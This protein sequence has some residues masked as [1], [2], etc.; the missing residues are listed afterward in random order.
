MMEK[1]VNWT[2][3]LGGCFDLER[4]DENGYTPATLC[5]NFLCMCVMSLSFAV[6][7]GVEVHDL[8]DGETYTTRFLCNIIVKG[9]V[10]HG[11]Y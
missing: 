6:L 11:K 3:K 8:F 5:M 4:W 10:I 9:Q 7:M 2:E 1:L